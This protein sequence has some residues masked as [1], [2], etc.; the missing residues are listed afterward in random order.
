MSCECGPYMQERGHIETC[1]KH[2]I[3]PPTMLLYDVSDVAHALKVDNR[4]IDK[5]LAAKI[6]AP[7]FKYITV[8]GKVF[9]DDLVAWREWHQQYSLPR[10]F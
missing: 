3:A 1:D 5:W 2:N 4:Q 6:G 7:W 8:G 9:W 10:G